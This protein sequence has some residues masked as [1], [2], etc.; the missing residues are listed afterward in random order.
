MAQ[1]RAVIKGQRGEASR[2]GSAR[3][4]ILATVDGWNSGVMVEGAVYA[5][6]GQDLFGI[7]VTG[8]SNRGQRMEYIGA[9]TV[10]DGKAVFIPA[11]R[12]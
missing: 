1:F 6:N 12:V 11:D 9:V 7:Y 4:G 5:G 3:T 10:K 8:G 2:L